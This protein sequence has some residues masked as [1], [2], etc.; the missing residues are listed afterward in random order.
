MKTKRFANKLILSTLLSA[1]LIV[2]FLI[3]GFQ[4][5]LAS[6]SVRIPAEWELHAATWIQWPVHWDE[7][8]LR[9]NLAAIIDALQEYEPVYILV[10]K[11]NQISDVKNYLQ[12]RG[13]PLT[14]LSFYVIPHNWAWMR[15][16]GPVYGVDSS[17]HFVQ[18]W[19]FDGWGGWGKPFGK[20]NKVPIKVAE[21]LGLPLVQYDLIVERGN[22]EFNGNDT[23][24]T[25]W[26]VQTLR[27]PDVTMAEQ[28]QIFKDAFGV[29]NVVWLLHGPS[30]D[31]T[32]GH[33]DGIARFIN[34]S[35]VAVNRF[36]D[37]DDPDAWVYE[38]AADIVE[39]AGF[40]V[41]RLD[42]PGYVTYK[43]ATFYCDYAN[44]YVANDVVV[45]TGFNVTEWDNAA[46]QTVQGWFPS[47]DVIVVETLQLWKDGG[48]VHCVTNDQP[49]P[50]VTL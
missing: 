46:K 45:M 50:S 38:E 3:M 27:N 7:M 10:N 34:A 23:L 1:L 9:P 17:G 39:A 21:Q 25:N 48:G 35:T 11:N 5:A 16:N 32:G 42:I 40:N 43:G 41:L 8:R 29:T 28:E 44:W 13:I 30:D 37:Q 4:A 24:I 6:S 20:D 31:P 33:V 36:V 49:D 19:E 26:A 15:D 47:R 2:A 22:L 14:N 18:D 12:N